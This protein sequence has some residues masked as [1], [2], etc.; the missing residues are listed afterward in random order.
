MRAFILN[1]ETGKHFQLTYLEPVIS[2][3]GPQASMTSANLPN[4]SLQPL[5]WAGHNTPSESLNLVIDGPDATEQ[6]TQLQTFKDPISKRVNGS[7]LIAPS[8]PI[9]RIQIGRLPLIRCVITS[10]TA[11]VNL[12]HVVDGNPNRYNVNLT[13]QQVPLSAVV[14]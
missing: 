7:D 10:V 11:Q 8:I 14:A 3:G 12:T 13:Y 2:I 1:T 6:F 9:C 5:F 4:V